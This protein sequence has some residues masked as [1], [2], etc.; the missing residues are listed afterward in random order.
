MI[1][2]SEEDQLEELAHIGMPFIEVHK[3]KISGCLENHCNTSDLIKDLGNRIFKVPIS[4]SCHSGDHS[5]M[6]SHPAHLVNADNS[7]SP[8]ALIPF[9]A[10]KSSLRV[11]HSTTKHP[12]LKFTV[13]SSFLPDILE[14]QLC[15]TLRVNETGG[16]GKQNGMLMLLDL[17]ENRD[18]HTTEHHHEHIPDENE[19]NLDTEDSLHDIA[20]K[21]QINAMLPV[22]KYGKG[23]YQM[24]SVKKM[25]ATDHF[26][27]L[28]SKLRNC[29]IESYD[30]CRT[31]NLLAE[32][33]CVP[34]ELQNMRVFHKN[35]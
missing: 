24:T 18:F 13:C 23:S 11:A 22:T 21:I 25:V 15:Y 34:W 28:S 32:C 1:A 8:S 7:F 19:M 35:L 33:E 26:L 6:V 14:G 16:K 2:I 9:C 27:G 12:K 31:K 29:E 30:E 5:A 10:F 17:N 4:E 3:N 20:A